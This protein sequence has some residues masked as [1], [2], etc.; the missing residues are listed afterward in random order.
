M[1]TSSVTMIAE[2]VGENAHIAQST[3]ALCCAMVS[4][5]FAVGEAREQCC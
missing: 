5:V 2:M 1:L 3:A 4:R